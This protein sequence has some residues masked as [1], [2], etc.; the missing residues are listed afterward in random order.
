MPRIEIAAE[1][2]I[3]LLGLSMT[4]TLLMSGVSTVFLGSLAI[5]VFRSPRL[6]PSGVQNAFEALMDMILGMM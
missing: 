1:P 2:I 5:V 4:N 6:I 3:S